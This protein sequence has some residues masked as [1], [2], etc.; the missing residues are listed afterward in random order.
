MRII[1]IISTSRHQ[2]GEAT[3]ISDIDTRISAGW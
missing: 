1:Y 3:Q 2:A